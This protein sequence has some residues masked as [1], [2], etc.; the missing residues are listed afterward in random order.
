MSE[1]T[2]TTAS[3]S[4]GCGEH[5][6]ADGAR[7]GADAVA[8][9]AATGAEACRADASGADAAC[10]DRICADEPRAEATCARTTCAETTCAETTCSPTNSEGAGAAGP[11]APGVLLR[12]PSMDCAVEEGE[13]RHALR[14]FSAL[15]GLQFQLAARTV[16]V[17]APSAD[18]PQIL[19][20]I[21]RAGFAPEVVSSTAAAQPAPDYSARE[22][23]R[24]GLALAMAI[25]AEVLAFMMPDSTLGTVL[26][27]AM[28]ATAIALAGFSVYRKGFAA[29]LQGRLNINAL[30]AVAVTGAFLIGQWPEAAMVM[31]LYAIAEL[32]EARAVDRARSAIKAL[33]DLAPDVA[34]TQGPDGSWRELA[35]ASVP[36]EAIVRV[37]PGGRVPLDGVIVSG[38]SAINQAPVTGESI[39]VDKSV[40]DSVFAGTINETGMLQLRVSAPA[41]EST[42]AR[43]IHAVE[44]AQGTRAPTQRLVDRFA[45]VYTP[46]VFLMA[47]AV[48]LLSPLVF[49]WTWSQSV[50]KA[51]VLLV[52]ACP[53][54]LVI[55]TPVTVVSGLARAARHGILIKGGVYL[56]QARHLRV[57]AFD[58]TGTITTGQPKLM[59]IEVL[60]EAGAPAGTARQS[61]LRW[62]A[63][64]AAQSD[65]PGSRWN[66]PARNPWSK[67]SWPWPG[68]ACKGRSMALR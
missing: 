25:G 47:V 68:A 27:M 7:S 54:A 46:L 18:M 28:A 60:D 42:L 65:H 66:L 35:V 55:A 5:C 56:E 30:M 23:R 37:R 32:I 33:L 20:A 49:D 34:E 43:I 2:R 36:T 22:M 63:A 13:I 21:R 6:A 3:R 67:T 44:Q 19:A 64:L 39:P 29:L 26:G 10:A 58:K 53:C 40:G 11:S 17:D 4:G 14:E 15:R 8:G 41:S 52:I 50:Y 48:A 31:A 45:A 9:L 38:S 57:V 59:A 1:P 61:V 12:I 16:S 62:A 24:Y 51:L